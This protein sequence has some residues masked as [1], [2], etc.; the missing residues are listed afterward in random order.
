[1]MDKLKLAGMSFPDHTQIYAKNFWVKI[2]K[3]T[4]TVKKRRGVQPIF[5]FPLIDLLFFGWFYYAR[6]G[7]VK[8]YAPV[9]NPVLDGILAL[10]FLI[11]FIGCAIFLISS[12]V[13]IRKWHGC[14]HKAIAAAMAGDLENIKKYSPIHDSCGGTYLFSLYLGMAAWF[15]FVG[16]PIGVF[17]FLLII[18]VLESR[19]F[20]KHN[21]LGI[22][23]G[24]QIQRITTTEPPD[25]ILEMGKRG[26]GALMMREGNS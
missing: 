24:R 15:T 7:L 3:D 21:R 11:F 19:Y 9:S 23:I 26:V 13:K 2:D 12:F 5:L 1:M 10:A 20:H 22:W 6:P 8:A 18:M 14:E 4:Y 17:S 25:E 16:S